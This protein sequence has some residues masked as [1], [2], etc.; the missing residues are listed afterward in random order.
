MNQKEG[1]NDKAFATITKS[2]MGEN[3]TRKRTRTGKY[4]LEEMRKKALILQQTLGRLPTNDEFMHDMFSAIKI[5][6]VEEE[7]NNPGSTG[8]YKPM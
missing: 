1:F 4:G 5:S 2:W 7:E 3:P 6:L 8:A